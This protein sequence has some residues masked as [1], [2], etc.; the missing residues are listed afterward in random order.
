VLIAHFLGVDHAGHTHG[1]DSAE[2]A[3]KLAEL[4]AVVLATAAALAADASHEATLLIVMGD[5]GMTWQ[6]DHGGGSDE[7]VRSALF[8]LRPHRSGGGAAPAA[9]E[10]MPQ[11]DFAPTAALLLGVPPPFG[12][13][14]RVCG[15]LWAAAGG[16]A[17]GL[18]AALRANAWQVARAVDAYAAK[19]SFQPDDVAALRALHASGAHDAF[20]RAA[21]ALARAQ[22]ASFRAGSMAAGLAT[23]AAALVVH[24]GT[25]HA[26]LGPGGSDA[27]AFATMAAVAA[28][29]V[30]AHIAG[31]FSVGA[32]QEEQAAAHAP[33]CAVAAAHAALVAWQ[34][35]RA[36]ATARAA[37]RARLR[38]ACALVLATA[39]IAACAMRGEDK[40]SS[41]APSSRAVFA[42]LAPLLL[43][44]RLLLPPPPPPGAKQSDRAA[45][46][47]AT[48][49][50]CHAAVGLHW[51]AHAVTAAGWALPPALA[52][53]A[54][55]ALPRVVF[56][57]GGGAALFAASGA[58]DGGSRG[59]GEA[60]A[61]ASRGVLAALC[62]PLLLLT[63]RAAPLLALLAA[64]QGALILRCHTPAAHA[65][66]AASPLPRCG[67]LSLAAASHFAAL[68]LFA[69]TGHRSSF[70]A[71]H[72]KAA[73]TARCAVAFCIAMHTCHAAD[74]S[75]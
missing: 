20:L 54:R 66:A 2:M 15:A 29:A 13:V 61:A 70:E 32:M 74:A 51:A 1:V 16:D 69:A 56:V 22:W 21:A 28:A 60:A 40:P 31:A 45:L 5:H 6:G 4:D 67:L 12:S 68:Q 34:L 24:A 17:A 43:L 49:R 38:D 63:G 9:A 47:A 46:L 36:P 42:A 35:L 39:G 73:F 44:P 72:F 8:A 14:G 19:G 52:H 59:V 27:D 55:I 11:I 71:L 23:L 26:A 62:A 50:G 18:A 10:D 53:A 3:A 7:E 65:G 57:A 64:A 48:V 41:E 58:L 75:C 37:A 33:M 30:V 25:L